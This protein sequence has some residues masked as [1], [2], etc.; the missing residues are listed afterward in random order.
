M[1]NR[2]AALLRLIAV[3]GTAFVGAEYFLTGC[4]RP[5][6]NRGEPFR[7]EEIALLD[8]VA[9]TIIPRTATPGAKDVAAGAFMAKVAH[10]CY[11]DVR[12][13]SFRDGIA[14]VDKLARKTFGKPFADGSAAER[15]A[16]LVQLDAEQKQHARDKDA[17]DAPHY[18]G[19]M[20]EL[21]I[22]AYFTSEA[23]STQALRYVESPGSYDGN[24][25]YAKGDR[26]WY[27]PSRRVG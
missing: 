25:P 11:S 6:A 2:R 5:S 10:D 27:N 20:K 22:L 7:A 3:T 8:D 13:A 17:G 14:A 1:M 21:T 23:G 15:T 18:F 12:F 9:D 26:A 19:I 16:L 4:A 24:V